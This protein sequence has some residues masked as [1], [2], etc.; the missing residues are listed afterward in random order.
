MRCFCGWNH[1]CFCELPCC[2]DAVISESIE[3]HRKRCA[4]A[5]QEPDYSVALV[6]AFPH[7]LKDFIENNSMVYVEGCYIHQSPFV[8]YEDKYGKSVCCEAGDILIVCRRRFACSDRDRYNVALL[9]TKMATDDTYT[10]TT[11]KELRQLKVYSDWPK[12]VFGRKFPGNNTPYN[13]HP[14]CQ[15]P[16]AQYLFV[17]DDCLS[18]SSP[19]RQMSTRLMTFGNFICEL[20]KWSTGRPIASFE[21]KDNHKRLDVWS[22]FI[23]DMLSSLKDAKFTR[24][25]SG[26]PDRAGSR[27]LDGPLRDLLVGDNGHENLDDSTLYNRRDD[28]DR[29]LGVLFV[30]I[31]ADESLMRA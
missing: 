25:N 19:D 28:E 3:R 21:D 27:M 26:Y 20:M 10:V 5:M 14:K 12:L 24:S 4:K 30:D 13:I 7:V 31:E 2:V 15:S 17:R 16:G 29:G 1:S 23:W 22:R 6:Y 8:A 11:D 18:V 9:Q